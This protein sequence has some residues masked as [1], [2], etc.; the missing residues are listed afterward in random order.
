[1]SSHAKIV[2]L[3]VATALLCTSTGVVAQTTKSRP[4][5]SAVT[6]NTCL[7]KLASGASR[8]RCEQ[9]AV[10]KKNAQNTD[11]AGA[12]R[13]SFLNPRTPGTGVVTVAS[14]NGRQDVITSST[15]LK[16]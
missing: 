13:S 5:T 16:K 2:G 11:V 12:T 9:V 4:A 10:R 1:M 14:S 6:A 3:S 15:S 8:T 7:E